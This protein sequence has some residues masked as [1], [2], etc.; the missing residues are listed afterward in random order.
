M[1]A[2]E[3]EKELTLVDHLVELRDRILK[4]LVAIVVIFLCLFPFANEI[5]VFIATPLISALPENSSMIAI[6]PTAPFSPRS[7]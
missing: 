1:S 6:D 3:D 5:Y 7:N 2:A 4:A